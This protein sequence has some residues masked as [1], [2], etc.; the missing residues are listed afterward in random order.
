MTRRTERRIFRIVG[1]PFRIFGTEV[2]R[3]NEAMGFARIST[4]AIISQAGSGNN[5]AARFEAGIGHE[6]K[7]FRGVRR[8]AARVI[9]V[10]HG[11]RR[12][13]LKFCRNAKRKFLPMRSYG[14]GP[15]LVV[16]GRNLDINHWGQQAED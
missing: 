11:S 13:N 8:V 6:P 16:G 2:I 5:A 1:C 14:V 7:P 10:R 12:L 9:A 4:L 15:N 3:S